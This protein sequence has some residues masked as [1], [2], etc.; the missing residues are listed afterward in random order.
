MHAHSKC[1]RRWVGSGHTIFCSFA[2]PSATNEKCQ[3]IN[4]D[5]NFLIEVA[6]TQVVNF[7]PLSKCHGL[8]GQKLSTMERESGGNQTN[9]NISNEIRQASLNVPT[10]DGRNKS[11]SSWNKYPL[12]R[13]G[14]LRYKYI[15][16][17][18]STTRVNN[19]L[20]LLPLAVYHCVLT[21]NSFVCAVCE[22]SPRSRASICAS[23]FAAA[24]FGISPA[25]YHWEGNKTAKNAQSKAGWS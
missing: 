25:F 9:S 14:W 1:Q 18:H 20:S 24:T 21:L 13:A 16:T 10:D 19:I 6:V 12:A 4:Y 17:G 11:M 22:R 15:H 23:V 2:F 5:N 3:A 7:S 8:C